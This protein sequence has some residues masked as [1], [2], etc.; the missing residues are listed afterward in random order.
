MTR[1]ISVF[2]YDDVVIVVDGGIRRI[3]SDATIIK[4]SEED[5]KKWYFEGGEKIEQE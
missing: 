4:M 1:P 2:K 5:I 3:I